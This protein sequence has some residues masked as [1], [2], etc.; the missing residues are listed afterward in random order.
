M[1]KKSMEEVWLRGGVDGYPG[2]LQPVVHAILQ[3]QEE[4]HDLMNCFPDN[5]LWEKPAGVANVAFHLQHIA[6]V[7]NRMS[8]YAKSEPL[9][10]VQFDF[11][12]HEGVFNEGITTNK[13]LNDL[14]CTISGF[15]KVVS[16]ID[17]NT[18]THLRTV[19]RAKLPSTVGGLLFH[20][21]EHMQ[22]HYGQLLVTVRILKYE[23]PD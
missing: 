10:E 12:K 22:R 8:T 19:G 14:D 17:V 18:L 16:N 4:I 3:A 2:L 20:A 15:L 11:L 23:K 21:A 7:L 13:L 6:G 9:T 5:L 1:M